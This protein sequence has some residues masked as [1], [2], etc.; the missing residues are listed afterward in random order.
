M[1]RS[2]AVSDGSML[3]A[4]III[5]CS[6]FLG[7]ASASPDSALDGPSA[8]DTIE[9]IDEDVD[10][11]DDVSVDEV[12]IENGRKMGREC[13][14]IGQ[15]TCLRF[16]PEATACAATRT[17]C[18]SAACAE[19]RSLVRSPCQLTQIRFRSGTRRCPL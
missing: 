10:P 1:N 16:K 2:H 15:T 13:T 9:G 14:C 18:R 6:S 11:A 3:A 7:C 8:A 4:V 19:M 12:V 5:G 17:A